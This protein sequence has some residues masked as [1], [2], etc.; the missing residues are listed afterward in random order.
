MHLEVSNLIKHIE[1]FRF[2]K[3]IA[4]FVEHEKICVV[5]ELFHKSVGFGSEG[6]DFSFDLSSDRRSLAFGKILGQ[7][8]EGIYRHNHNNRAAFIELVG[9]TFKIGVVYEIKGIVFY[10]VRYIIGF[11]NGIAPPAVK[12]IGLIVEAKV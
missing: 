4:A 7:L 8:V 9:H 5:V 6:L 10:S 2:N 12:Q 11:V 3:G 1:F